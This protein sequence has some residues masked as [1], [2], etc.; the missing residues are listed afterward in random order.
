MECNEFRLGEYVRVVEGKNLPY[1]GHTGVVSHKREVYNCVTG[2]RIKKYTV[3]FFGAGIVE[4]CGWHLEPAFT[5]GVPQ[6]TTGYK[7]IVEHNTNI[8]TVITLSVRRSGEWTE[9]DHKVTLGN[10]HRDVKEFLEAV[11][12]RVGDW[13]EH[14]DSLS[15]YSGKIVCV[16]SNDSGYIPGKVYVVE[17]G[18]IRNAEPDANVPAKAFKSVDEI[19][20]YFTRYKFIPFIEL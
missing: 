8:G 1:A 9:L 7:L 13:I 4:F 14:P 5:D 12:K 15:G 10:G 17:N 16:E 2:K 18:I 3:E 11:Q 20:M 6:E 19:N